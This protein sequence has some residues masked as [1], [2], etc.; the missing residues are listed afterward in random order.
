MHQILFA[1]AIFGLKKLQVAPPKLDPHIESGFLYVAGTAAISEL[2]GRH[3]AGGT[4]VTTESPRRR[5]ATW[6][7]LRSSSNHQT[8][9]LA[10]SSYPLEIVNRLVLQLRFFLLILTVLITDLSVFLK[11]QTDDGA[12]LRNVSFKDTTMN[13]CRV[14]FAFKFLVNLR[15]KQTSLTMINKLCLTLF[16]QE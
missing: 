13:F 10:F 11:F 6:T 4:A 3:E 12:G 8:R 7:C 2:W 14:F 15:F 16:V 9:N 1:L 5:G